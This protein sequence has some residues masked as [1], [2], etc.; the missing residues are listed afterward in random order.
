MVDEVS[1]DG[2]AQSDID[3]EN[4]LHCL[5]PELEEAKVAID[6]QTLEIGPIESTSTAQKKLRITNTGSRGLFSC[7]ARLQDDFPGMILKQDMGGVDIILLPGESAEIALEIEAPVLRPNQGYS[8]TLILTKNT[9]S[10]EGTIA[11]PVSFF[12]DYPFKQKARSPLSVDGKQVDSLIEL[13]EQVYQMWLTAGETTLPNGVVGW[14]KDSLQEKALSERMEEISKAAIKPSEKCYR[15]LKLTGV[16]HR[17]RLIQL[18]RKQLLDE[19]EEERVRRIR[20]IDDKVQARIDE[21]RQKTFNKPTETSYPFLLFALIIAVICGGIGALG[22][23]AVGWIIGL[24]VGTAI[25]YGYRTVRSNTA[26]LQYRN[27]IGNE[28]EGSRRAIEQNIQ[29]KVKNIDL[30]LISIEEHYSRPLEESIRA[31]R[32]EESTEQIISYK[33]LKYNYIPLAAT[34]CA[35][36]II[37]LLII[38]HFTGTTKPTDRVPAASTLKITKAVIAEGLDSNKNP[39]GIATR[40]PDGNKTLY[41]YISYTGGIP[42]KTIFLYRWYKGSSEIANSQ[43]TLKYASGNAWSPLSYNYGPGTYE[44]RLYIDGKESRKSSFTIEGITKPQ[45]IGEIQTKPFRMK[46]WDYGPGKGKGVDIQLVYVDVKQGKITVGFSVK[47]NGHKDILL[48]GKALKPDSSGYFY[49]ESLYIV[50]DK[51]KKVYS[52]T[53]FVGGRQ[54]KFNSNANRINID[55]GEEVIIFAEFPMVSNDAKSFRFVSPKLHGH[56]ND[57]WW[58]RIPLESFKIRE[59]IPPPSALPKI[60]IAQLEEEIN[61]NLRLQKELKEVSVKVKEDLVAT[62]GGY[63]DNPG[64]KALAINI[65]KS[66][67]ELK[68]IEDNI[69]VK[70]PSPPPIDIAKLEFEINS[71]LRSKG[72]KD[73]YAEVNKDLM[74]ILWGSVDRRDDKAEALTIARAYKEL[75]WVRD[76]IEVRLPLPPPIDIPKLEGEI[77]RALRRAGIMGVT[78]MVSDDLEVT[79]KG[80]V[81]TTKQKNVAFKIA[82]NFKGVKSVRDNV[83]IVELR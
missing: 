66:Y 33:S 13:A 19:M 71:A 18:L 53:G 8:N 74:A 43:L 64:D 23:G 62:L 70:L 65:A 5:D 35:F 60:D 50:D 34:L 9:Y 58:D 59:N 55:S 56:Q 27:A 51:G 11:I 80:S 6:P 40:F 12:V 76:N 29:D 77:N 22:T 28:T 75:R 67:K 36:M 7:S 39:V 32:V 61:S 52:T 48:Y 2:K 69:H 79:L 31:S 10:S 42:N 81:A 47:S 21:Q 4:F 44:V 14:I 78:A 1:K 45:P 41:Y 30:D 25:A 68:K 17:E 37:P 82:G 3:F 73:V 38:G 83:F 63:V 54:S 57:W 26:A 46:T 72:L 49:G 16:I 20:E 24:L 15:F